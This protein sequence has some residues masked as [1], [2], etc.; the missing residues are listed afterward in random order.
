VLL[1]EQRGACYE[2]AD[3]V[4]VGPRSL[5]A[6]DIIPEASGLAVVEQCLTYIAIHFASE[7]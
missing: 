3:P 1:K 7:W 5:V 4:N 2:V 6:A